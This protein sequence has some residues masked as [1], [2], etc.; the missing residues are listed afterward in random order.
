[1]NDR[2]QRGGSVDCRSNPAA[3]SPDEGRPWPTVMVLP[4]VACVPWRAGPAEI[5]DGLKRRIA[6][7]GIDE[8]AAAW[9][10]GDPCGADSERSGDELLP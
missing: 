5:A 2:L 6:A 9:S 4:S 8:M 3:R 1:V 10:P 7:Q